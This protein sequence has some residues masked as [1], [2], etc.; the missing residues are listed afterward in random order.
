MRQIQKNNNKTQDNTKQARP[1]ERQQDY[2]ETSGN[3]TNSGNKEI[4][5]VREH[6]NDK[7]QNYSHDPRHTTTWPEPITD[8]STQLG[9]HNNTRYTQDST[10]ENKSTWPNLHNG[11][12]DTEGGARGVST[13][14]CRSGT[15]C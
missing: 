1:K 15:R 7:H 10:Q 13:T 8:K 9:Q 3:K 4:S 14:R 2:R 6:T 12:P 11:T 5:R